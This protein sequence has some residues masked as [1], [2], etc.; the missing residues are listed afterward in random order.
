MSETVVNA[1]A[2]LSPISH[3]H[4]SPLLRVARATRYLPK[5][6]GLSLLLGCYQRIFPAGTRFRI[7][8]F[9]GDLM[10]DV[11]IC[12][13]IGINLWHTPQL[14]ENLERELFCSAVK[15]GCTVLDVGANLGIYTLL[16]AKGGAR[17]FSIEADPLNASALRK[18]VELN[19]FARQ[20]S[21][22]EMAATSREEEVELYRNPRNSGGSSLYAS[23][24]CGRAQPVPVAGRSIDALELP[25]IDV[26]KMDIEGAELSALKGMTETLKRSP[27]LH[28]LIECFQDGPNL[29]R[30]LRQHFAHVH[31]VGAAEIADDRLPAYCN[32]WAWN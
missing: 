30:F 10:L 14:Y 32:L 7:D 29:V 11:N 13:T 26:C 20:V 3:A 25:A 28:L 17:V 24:C 31:V 9:D 6:A 18:H 1:P 16:A 19:H 21:I 23:A 2:A 8:D 12:E 15:P 22:Y 5:F 27:K 4:P